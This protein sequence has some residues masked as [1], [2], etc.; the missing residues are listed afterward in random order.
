MAFKILAGIV[1][2]VL[3]LLYLGPIALKLKEPALTLVIVVGIGLMLIDLWQSW[4]SK[5]D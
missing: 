2:V 5:G 4:Q 3:M 1:A